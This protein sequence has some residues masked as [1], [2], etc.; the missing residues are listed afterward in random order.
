M[1]Y[2]SLLQYDIGEFIDSPYIF[3]GRRV[4]RVTRVLSNMQEEYLMQWANSLG[5]RRQSYTKTLEL[6]SDIGSETHNAIEYYLK[7]GN[8]KEFTNLEAK[9]SFR[10][11]LDYWTK[12]CFTNEVQVLGLE[13]TLI[14]PYYGG[15]CDMIVR[16]NGKTYLYDFKTSN[17][18][19]HKYFS[20]LAAYRE[21]LEKNL[22]IP[23]D[24][25]CV[26]QLYKRKSGFSE[27]MIPFTCQ[28]NIDYID[29]CFNA[30]MSYVAAYYQ[31]V[32]MEQQFKLMGGKWS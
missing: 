14:G 30:F 8:R 19:G 22:F 7:T 4:P 17:H 16:I 10:N 5:W 24:G 15:T 25:V 2:S 6:A 1:D 26:L 9:Q 12:L 29:N 3:F 13:E 31:K 32:F 23:I 11:F 21:I 27:Y 18:I 28:E 20:Q